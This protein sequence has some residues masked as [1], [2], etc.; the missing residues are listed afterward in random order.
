VRA[1]EVKG[2]AL[3]RPQAVLEMPNVQAPL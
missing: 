2:S 3:F 1:R